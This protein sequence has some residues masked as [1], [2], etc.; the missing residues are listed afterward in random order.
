MKLTHIFNYN[1]SQHWE[2]FETKPCFNV[3]QSRVPLRICGIMA[4]LAQANHYV[5]AKHTQLFFS[6]RSIIGGM[7]MKAK[8]QCSSM[9][10]NYHQENSWDIISKYGL[11]DIHSNQKSKEPLCHLNDQ[12]V[13]SS[14]LTIPY[15]NALE[16]T[17]HYSQQFKDD[18]RKSISTQILTNTYNNVI[19]EWSW[20]DSD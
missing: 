19:D 8:K 10:G 15:K 13:S 2:K 11:T 1:T 16:L 4:R 14:H 9:N 20:S 17:H 18:S 12:N 5:L 6:R 3:Q 7:D